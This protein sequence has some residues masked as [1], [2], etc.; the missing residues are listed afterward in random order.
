MRLI[1]FPLEDLERV[2]FEAGAPAADRLIAGAPVFRTWTFDARDDDTLYSGVWE[3]TPGKWRVVYDEW[4]FCSLLSGRSIVTR[5]GHPPEVLGSGDSFILEPGF[6]GTW[7][8]IDTT[9]KLFVVRLAP[10]R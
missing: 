10:N 7:E 6:Q 5:D 8:V 2:P 3:S 1:R 9:R 4:E